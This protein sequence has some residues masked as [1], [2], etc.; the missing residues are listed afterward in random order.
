MKEW[1]VWYQAEEHP[2]RGRACV[3]LSMESEVGIV[4]GVDS[5]KGKVVGGEVREETGVWWAG[6]MD[7]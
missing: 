2:G 5:A 6:H 4:A 3:W 1:A 7:P